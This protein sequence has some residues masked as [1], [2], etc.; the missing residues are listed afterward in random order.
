MKVLKIGNKDYVVKFTSKVIR[1]LNAKG[2]TLTSLST[3]MEKLNLM[4]TT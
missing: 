4:L 1:E 3:D 2:I